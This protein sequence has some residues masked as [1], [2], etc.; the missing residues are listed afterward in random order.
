MLFPIAIEL[1]DAKHAYGVIVPDLPGCFSAGDT[2]EEAIANA[3]EAILLHLEDDFAPGNARVPSVTALA[4][5]QS[6]KE[7]RGFAWGVV[8]V[9]LGKLSAKSLRVNI[10]VPERLLNTID[11][12]AERHG[13]SRSAFLT[14][15]A[16]EAMAKDAA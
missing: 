11:D 15:A 1:G 10:T 7:Y 12:Y 13:E 8:D 9:D 4:E 6:R 16:L 14:R 2:M 3:E 5:L